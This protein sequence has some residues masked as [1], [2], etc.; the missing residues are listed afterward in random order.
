MPDE[1]DSAYLVP[2]GSVERWLDEV[3]DGLT[4]TGAGG[5]RA[6]IEIED[7]LRA[8]VADE[9]DRG[10]DPA[11]AEHAAVTR[12]GSPAKIARDI[13]AAHRNLLRPAL[14]GVWALT[15]AVLLSLGLATTVTEAL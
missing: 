8:A 13:R 5:R 1:N 4:G 9:R 11:A 2:D 14:T 15:G 10:L 6:L 7:H 12:F 3:F